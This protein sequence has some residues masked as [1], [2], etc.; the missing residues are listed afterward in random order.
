MI[1][2]SQKLEQPRCLSQ[3]KMDEENVVHIHNGGIHSHAMR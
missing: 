1:E 2:N 3:R